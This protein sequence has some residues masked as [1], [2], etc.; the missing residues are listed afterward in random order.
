MPVV[1]NLEDHV[2]VGSGCACIGTLIPV[3]S[4]G[5]TEFWIRDGGGDPPNQENTGGVPPPGGN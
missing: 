2:D 1:E 3:H 4:T 5:N